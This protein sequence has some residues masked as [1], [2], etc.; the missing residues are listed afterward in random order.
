MEIVIDRPEV[1]NALDLDAFAALA[2]AWDQLENESSVR[3]AIITGQGDKAFCAGA[4]LTSAVPVT[5]ASGELGDNFKA[6]LAEGRPHKPII[7]AVNGYCIGAGLILLLG[8]DIRI[9]SESAVFGLGG[10]RLGYYAPAAIPLLVGQLGYVTA[11][12][13]ALEARRYTSHEAVG[14]GIVSRVVSASELLGAARKTAAE[15][16]TFDD[17][18]VRATVRGLQAAQRDE[19]KFAQ[20]K[21]IF[22]GW[23]ENRRS[24][25]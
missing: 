20:D 4:D 1:R 9:A 15:I 21:E 23:M 10:I 16:A 22:T 6:L 7:A 12:S 25:T 14:A 5:I 18:T 13:I 19:S 17:D 11:A 3:V 8:T 2:S 24:D